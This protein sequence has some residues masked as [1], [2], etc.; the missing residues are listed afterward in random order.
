MIEYPS[1]V[2]EGYARIL[3]NTVQGNKV[4]LRHYLVGDVVLPSEIDHLHAVVNVVVEPLDHETAI[5][6][7]SRQR[8]RDDEIMYRNIGFSLVDKVLPHLDWLYTHT[9]RGFINEDGYRAVQ[10]TQVELAQDLFG[11]RQ[12][13]NRNLRRLEDEGIIKR[14]YGSIALMPVKA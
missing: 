8:K 3:S 10:I 4:T 2:A 11:E 12:T 13:V 7:L 1:V 6:R 9:P 5:E 14:Q